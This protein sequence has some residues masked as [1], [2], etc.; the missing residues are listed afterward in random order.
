VTPEQG[1]H[2]YNRG[3]HTANP[4]RSAGLTTLFY[5]GVFG[6]AAFELAKVYLIMPMPGSQRMNS[7]DVA[8]VLHTWRWAFRLVAVLAVLA[9]IRTAFAVRLRWQWVPVLAILLAA[10]AAWTFNFVMAADSMFKQPQHLVLKTRSENRV[11]ESSVVVVAERGG[12]AKA[13]PIRFLVYHHQVPDTIG[14]APV[15]VTY[16]SVCRSGRVFEPLVGGQ[17]E[18]FRLVGMDQFNAMFED[19]QT[20]SWWRQA[21][22]SAVTG[23]LK[24]TRLSEVTSVQLT[25]AQFFALHPNGLVMQP[26]E[27]FVNDYDT[28]GRFERGESTGSLTRTDRGSWNDKSWVIGVE[29]AGVSKAYDWN[30][31]KTDRVINDVVGGTPIVVALASDATGFVAFE[32]PNN[33]DEFGVDGD[34]LRGNGRTYDFSGRET[35]GSAAPLKRLSASQEFWHSWRSFHPATVHDAPVDSGSQK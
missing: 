6:L 3:V 27:A 35:S 24:G 14:G 15:L 28:N 19:R 32:R 9:G 25:L 23:P 13:W 4:Q 26:D 33:S 5:L 18:T 11:D 31:L 2:R 12:E 1:P 10:G 7:L 22:G 30:R 8:Y 16:C 17:L 21:T 29:L 34:L 20:G